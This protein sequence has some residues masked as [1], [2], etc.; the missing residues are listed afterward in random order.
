[1]LFSSFIDNIN[2]QNILGYWFCGMLFLH[3]IANI[4]VIAIVTA[5]KKLQDFKRWRIIR[6]EMAQTKKIMQERKQKSKHD[7]AK[8]RQTL[9][10]EAVKEEY[11]WDGGYF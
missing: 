8:R 11:N 9:M 6:R 4:T 7:Y 10:D 1:M 3:L 2:V 5:K